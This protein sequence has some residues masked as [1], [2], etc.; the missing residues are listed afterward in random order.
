L[1]QTLQQI[2]NINSTMY[3]TISSQSKLVV[4]AATSTMEPGF[5]VMEPPAPPASVCFFNFNILSIN[6]QNYFLESASNKGIGREY[7]C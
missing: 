5:Y 2:S 3:S 1:E 6:E 7:L 4:D